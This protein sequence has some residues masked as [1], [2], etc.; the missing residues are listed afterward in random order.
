MTKNEKKVININYTS[1]IPR[2]KIKKIHLNKQVRRKNLLNIKISS[3]IS[4]IK[5]L[6][7]RTFQEFYFLYKHK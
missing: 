6:L 3:G 5:G 1:I 7:P 2:G 4:F